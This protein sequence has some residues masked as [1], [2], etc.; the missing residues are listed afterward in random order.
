MYYLCTQIL[1]TQLKSYRDTRV[2]R[3]TTRYCE[4]PPHLSLRGAVG[5]EANHD[6]W[7]CEG[8]N[9]KHEGNLYLITKTDK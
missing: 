9:V 2:A 1:L 6:E 3:Q 4:A 5:D 7:V 8:S